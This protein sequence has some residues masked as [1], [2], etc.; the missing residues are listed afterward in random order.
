MLFR[1]NAIPRAQ[2]PLSL[3]P[4]IRFLDG[5]FLRQIQASHA[6]GF[7][8]QGFGLGDELVGHSLTCGQAQNCAILRTLATQQAGQLA[9]VDVGDG[10]CLV[11]NQVARQISLRTE[12]AGDQRQV[13]DDQ[14]SRM[15]M[16]LF[17]VF[18][19]RAVVSDVRIGERD[20][21]LAITGIRQDFLVA[22]DGRDRKSTRLNSSH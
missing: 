18:C 7:E 9:G 21:L 12:V 3:C 2:R 5:D 8:R 10:H 22:R 14:A 4:V 11:G 13:M 20:D 1:S 6:G 16:G 19:I 15:N 17:R